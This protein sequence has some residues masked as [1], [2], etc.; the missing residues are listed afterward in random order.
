MSTP[1][2]LLPGPDP[3]YRFLPGGEP[4]SSGVVATPGW[5]VVH[6]TL[7]APVPW[8]EGFAAIERHLRAHGRP[9]AA[10]CAIELRIPSPLSFTGFTEFN[11]SYRAVLGEWGLLVDGRNPVART[12]VA[13]VVGPP[14][15]PSLYAFSHTVAG[16]TARPTFVAAGAG[17]LRPGPASR[18]SV[19]RLDDT[20]PRAM[21]EKAAYVM[22]VMQSR[23]TGL[24]GSWSDV[25]QVGVYTVH[26]LEDFLATE[27]L[28]VMGPAAIHGVHWYL[29]H[30]PISGLAY[31]M[32]LRGVGRELRISAAGGA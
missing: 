7:Q 2:P 3:S 20:S 17:E 18:E 10:L 24:G 6:V 15:E 1:A 14:P 31:K 5:E 32:D 13:P 27:I 4:Y 12:N 11:R 8:R 21:R 25:T 29:A 19:V 23:L 16:D 22:G 26:P 28:A 9:R 30:P